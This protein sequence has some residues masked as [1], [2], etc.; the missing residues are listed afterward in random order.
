MPFADTLRLLPAALLVAIHAH[1]LVAQ[2]AQPAA[3]AATPITVAPG[4]ARIRGDRLRPME[5]A[6]TLRMTTPDGRT[7]DVGRL[8]ESFATTTWAGRPA[9][10]RVTAYETPMGMV[11]DSSVMEP[12]TLAPIAHRGH[13]P[14]QVMRLDWDGARVTGTVTRPGEAPQPAAPSPAVATFDSNGID[15][16]A[17]LIDLAPGE[18]VRIP[19]YLHERGGLQWYTITASAGAGGGLQLEVAGDRPALRLT[20][21]PV[22]HHLRDFVMLLPNGATMQRVP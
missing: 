14:R 1:P 11:T 18:R 20:V 8:R 17:M 12:T 3:A 21:D 15:L 5:L 22:T 19:T 13:G 2:A 7:R 6:F 10:V 4:D 9:I 16:L